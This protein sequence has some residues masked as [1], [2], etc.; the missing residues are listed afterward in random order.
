MAC[1]LL[2]DADAV[3]ADREGWH[4]QR[5]QGVTASEIAVILGIAPKA[6]GSAFKLYHDKILGEDDWDNEAMAYG[7]YVEDYIAERFA[8]AH[9]ELTVAAGGLYCSVDRPWQMAT[10]DRI[11]YDRMPLELLDVL[12]PADALAPV[13]CKSAGSYEEWGADPD[14]GEIPDHYRAQ[15]LWECDV[16]GAA[17]AFVP[18]LQPSRKVKTYT[19]EVTA[20]DRA[21]IL[22]MRERAL[23]FLGRVAR[24]DP[25]PVDWT[26]ATA[27]ALRRLHPD[28][29]DTTARVPRKLA[30]RYTAALEAKDAAE[31]RLGLARNEILQRMGPARAAAALDG[32]QL[33]EVATRRKYGQRRVDVDDLR[34]RFPDQARACTKTTPVDQLVRGRYTKR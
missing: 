1:K 27:T 23:G 26:P 31:Q 32:G 30:D 20:A 16:L 24:R 28:L 2:M 18:V 34:A 13:Q 3:E 8:A 12:D 6:Y 4:A 17:V 5:R 29:D 19:V 21:D 11:A 15:V 7:R 10:F 33:V 14:D 25:P 22:V 9:P